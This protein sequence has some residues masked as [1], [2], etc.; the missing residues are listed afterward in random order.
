[1]PDAPPD[2]LVH[3]PYRGN[4]VPVCPSDSLTTLCKVFSS[5]STGDHLGV[6]AQMFLSQLRLWLM[7]FA[8]KVFPF[9][10]DSRIINQ[11][12]RDADD[13]ASTSQ[14][15]VEVQTLTHLPSART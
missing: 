12:V 6:V 15:I 3:L 8:V 9:Q 13:K 7:E 4:L 5:T 10:E 14:L 1:M 2:D 11:H